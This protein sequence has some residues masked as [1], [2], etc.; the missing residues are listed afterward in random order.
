MFLYLR[1]FYGYVGEY[2]FY[3]FMVKQETMEFLSLDVYLKK[4][5]SYIRTRV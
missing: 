5:K 3:D 2:F 4:I 1:L